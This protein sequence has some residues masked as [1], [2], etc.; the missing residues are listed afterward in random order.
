MRGVVAGVTVVGLGG[1]SGIGAA[2]DEETVSIIDVEQL[3]DDDA[4]DYFDAA[5]EH[6]H[7]ET[8]VEETAGDQLELRP[9]EVTAF[10]LK[11]ND[12]E[13]NERDPTTVVAPLDGEV[14][15]HCALLMVDGGDVPNGFGH[16]VTPEGDHYVSKTY[17]L[18]DEETTHVDTVELDEGDLDDPDK[19]NHLYLGGPEGYEEAWPVRFRG[20]FVEIEVEGE[21]EILHDGG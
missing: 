12:E 6:E 3:P 19:P 18:E 8:F 11:T 13:F 16:A 4:Q 15:G 9:D 20:D 5:M 1:A 10:A 21:W 14:G 7:V 2:S 17:Q